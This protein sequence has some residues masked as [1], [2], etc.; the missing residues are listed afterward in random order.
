VLKI[1]TER[2]SRHGTDFG[3][4][5]SSWTTRTAQPASLSGAIQDAIALTVAAG[6][7]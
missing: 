6:S 4:I 2:T 5:P 7:Q 3:G 1:G